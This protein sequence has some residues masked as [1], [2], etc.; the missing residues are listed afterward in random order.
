MSSAAIRYS[1]AFFVLYIECFDAED[2]QHI[3]HNK[4]QAAPARRRHRAVD[5]VI[6]LFRECRGTQT[7]FIHGE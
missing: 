5:E 4:F 6:I 3:P 1:L 7:V 2:K